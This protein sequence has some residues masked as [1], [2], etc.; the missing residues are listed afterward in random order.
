MNPVYSDSYLDEYYNNYTH[1]EYSQIIIDEQHFTANDNLQIVEKYLGHTG[2]MLDYGCGNGEHSNVALKRGWDVVGYDVDCATAENISSKYNFEY[3]CGS[4]ES[5]SLAD[6]MFDLVYANQVVE[7]LKAPVKELGLIHGLIKKDGVFLVAVPNIH[8]LSRRVK[9]LLEKIGLR[10]KNIGK[11]YDSDHHVFYY[12]KKSICNL[13]K[14]AGF[15]IIYTYNSKKP[16]LNQNSISKFFRR[17]IFEKIIPNSALLV[18]AK[19]I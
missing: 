8:S 18:L 1:S 3:L 17:N 5:L 12:D 2:S 10:R 13:L 15:E 16:K 7:H 11:Y 19:K 4:F 6:E 9:F 14:V